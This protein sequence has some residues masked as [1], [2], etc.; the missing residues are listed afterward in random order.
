MKKILDRFKFNGTLPAA[1]ESARKEE[2]KLKQ[3]DNRRDF[4]KKSA[5]GGLTL[6]LMFDTQPEKELEYITQKVK[7]SSAPTDL[8]ITDLRVAVVTGAPM[9]CPILRID[10][11]QGISG[12]GESGADHSPHPEQ[13]EGP[14][15]MIRNGASI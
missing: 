15:P 4:I 2:N 14:S 8:K 3:G 9:T 11:N 6:G 1:P 10:T 7:R 12:Y 13:R 5:L